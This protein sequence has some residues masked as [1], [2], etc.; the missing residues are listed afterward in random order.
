MRSRKDSTILKA[1]F[2]VIDAFL[3]L[4]MLEAEMPSVE[5][6]VVTALDFTPL[7]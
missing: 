7:K 4:A 1:I 3:I 2:L 6:K 5:D